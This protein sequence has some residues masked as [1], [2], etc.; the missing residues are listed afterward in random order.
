MHPFNRLFLTFSLA[1]IVSS[2]FAFS[3]EG[4][5]PEDAGLTIAK[6]VDHRDTG[7]VDS[8]ASMLMILRDRKDSESRRKISNKTLET[9]TD[10]DKKYFNI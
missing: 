7:F 9:K 4:L 8:T 1:T 5:S 2:S 10:G 3:L 6:E